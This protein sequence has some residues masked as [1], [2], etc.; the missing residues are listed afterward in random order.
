DGILVIAGREHA[1]INIGGDKLN[2]ERIEAA[3]SSFIR[4]R[5]AAA[6]A[7]VTPLGLQQVRCAVVWD[8][9]ANMSGLEE[10][11]VKA[12]PPMFIPQTFIAVDAIPRNSSGKI[13]RGKLNELAAKRANGR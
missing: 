10:Q 7:T 11:P 5:D 4:V 2:P 12:L 1:V 6:F 3:L 9:E 13:D 8:G